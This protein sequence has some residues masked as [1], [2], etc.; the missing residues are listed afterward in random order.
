MFYF[1][2]SKQAQLFILIVA[3]Y[4]ILFFSFAQRETKKIVHRIT[5]AIYFPDIF[6][7]IPTYIHST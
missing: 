5:F 3:L 7:I 4:F 6:I 1:L 2:T